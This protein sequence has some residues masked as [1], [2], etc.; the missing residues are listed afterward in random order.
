MSDWIKVTL[1]LTCRVKCEKL[2]GLQDRRFD[3]AQDLAKCLAF[4]AITAFRVWEL[5]RLAH[6]HPKEPA[7]EHE[8]RMVLTVLCLVARWRHLKV[9][10]GPPEAMTM[11]DYVV[12]VASLAGFHPSKRQPLPGTQKLWKGVLLLN[13]S[14]Q[15]YEATLAHLGHRDD[16]GHG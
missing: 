12:L 11:T 14:I 7:C 13:N 4:D 9:P 8:S 15:T 16:P 3:Q 2:I 1:K 6:E 10:R 5:S